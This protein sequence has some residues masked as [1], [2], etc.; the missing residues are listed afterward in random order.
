MSLPMEDSF[1]TSDPSPEK[2]SL[3]RTA[4][5]AFE[6]SA[7]LSSFSVASTSDHDDYTVKCFK[8]CEEAAMA[9]TSS[10]VSED[11]KYRERR[12]KNNIASQRSRASRKQK[13]NDLQEKAADLERQNGELK[14]RVEELENL[15][16]EM[17]ELLVQT[18]AQAK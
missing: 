10:A 14:Q 4:A 17:K 13:N 3:K 1:P 12:R 2:R 9:T 8:S 18:L 5:E 6:S 7:E 11:A 15:A 16:K